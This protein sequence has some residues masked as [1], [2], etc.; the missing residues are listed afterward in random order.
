LL[1]GLNGL[2]NGG[3]HL[4]IIEA[5]RA[6]EASAVAPYKYTSLL[7]S[8]LFSV[9]VFAHLPGP[10]TVLGALLVV[11]GGLYILRREQRAATVRAHAVPR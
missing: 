7:W 3:A 11:A 10:G 6:A 4:L 8:V 9:V 5:L 2:L 1:L